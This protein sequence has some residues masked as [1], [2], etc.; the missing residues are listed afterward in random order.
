MSQTHFGFETVDEKDK[1]TRVRGVFDSVASKYDVMNDLMSGGLHRAWKAYTLMVANL[2]EGDRAL[3]IAGEHFRVG[4]AKNG[5]AKLRHL[6]GGKFAAFP[7]SHE[8][9]KARSANKDFAEIRLRHHA[10]CGVGP[11]IE[12]DQRSPERNAGDEGTGAIY[13]VEHPGKRA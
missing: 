10:N 7:V 8:F 9:R 6:A 13:R 2:K 5:I 3:D 12:R 1:A 4:A 11:V